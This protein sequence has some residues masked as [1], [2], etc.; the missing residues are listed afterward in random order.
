MRRFM[1]KKVVESFKEEAVTGTRKFKSKATKM[2]WAE[3]THS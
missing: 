1:A 3:I 2:V